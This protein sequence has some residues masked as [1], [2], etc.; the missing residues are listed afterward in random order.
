MLFKVLHWPF[1][2]VMIGLGLVTFLGS[3][4]IHFS[5]KPSKNAIDFLKVVWVA[6]YSLIS[7]NS[8]FHLFKL[9]FKQAPSLLF[10]ILILY[11]LK[12]HYLN[13]KK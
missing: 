11:Y 7:F 1:G 5:K 4:T 2:N 12:T 10:L 13:F 6:C 9:D 8:I 3:Y